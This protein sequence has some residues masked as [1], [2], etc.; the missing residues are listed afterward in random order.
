MN[1]DEV[2]ANTQFALQGHPRGVAAGDY[3]GMFCLDKLRISETNGSAVPS[4]V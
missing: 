3:K 2:V 1:G 4:L